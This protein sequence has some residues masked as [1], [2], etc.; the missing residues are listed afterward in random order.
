MNRPETEDELATMLGEPAMPVRVVITCYYSMR[1][2]RPPP[3]ARK[4]C[5]LAA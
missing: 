4:S 5:S 3:C 1:R 2:T